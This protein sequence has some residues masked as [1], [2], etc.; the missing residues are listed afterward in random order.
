VGWV[1]SGRKANKRIL[2][3]VKGL[4]SHFGDSQEVFAARLGLSKRTNVSYETYR[5]PTTAVFARFAKAASDQG[6]FDLVSEFIRALG[7]DLGL[8]DIKGLVMPCAPGSHAEPG[9]LLAQFEG[10]QARM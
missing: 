6:R 9:Y 10:Q 8:S 1:E 4:R 2:E 3:G 5:R 7:T